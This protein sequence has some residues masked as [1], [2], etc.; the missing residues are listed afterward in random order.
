VREY[1]NDPRQV[2]AVI[3]GG[4]STII[5]AGAIGKDWANL[6]AGVQMVLP[7]G[8]SS[9]INYR[10]MVMQGAINHSIEGSL[11]LEF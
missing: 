2:Q 1:A 8:L 9:L 6:G 7:N 11:R 10:S 3:Q 5:S 4:G